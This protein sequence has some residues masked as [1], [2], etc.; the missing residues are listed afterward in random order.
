[1]LGA[2]LGDTRQA[3]TA[4]EHPAPLASKGYEENTN[5][6]E[7]LLAQG[8]AVHS[9]A[10]AQAGIKLSLWVGSDFCTLAHPQGKNELL[11]VGLIFV[12][13]PS[14][15]PQPQVSLCHW[16]IAV[17]Y[18]RGDERLYEASN[19]RSGLT[20]SLYIHQAPTTAEL[21]EY[22]QSRW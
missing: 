14:L 7:M 10:G 1:M 21:L 12:R 11:Q 19:T 4:V 16:D 13:A 6:T 22:I 5:T 20:R 17:K 15:V 9:E 3:Q 2:V 18:T 8:P